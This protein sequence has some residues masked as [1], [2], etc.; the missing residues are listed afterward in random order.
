MKT[1]SSLLIALAIGAGSSWW[2]TSDRLHAK[3]GEQV[4]ALDKAVK[5][6]DASIE[7]L[8]GDVK[9]L[10]GTIADNNRR[11]LEGQK[12]YD[13]AVATAERDL[14]ALRKEYQARGKRIAELEKIKAPVVDVKSMS[15]EEIAVELGD[16][17]RAILINNSYEGGPFHY[18]F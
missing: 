15:T 1:I 14:A 16:C 4:A 10:R 5:D 2:F 12:A 7:N 9:T 13:E 17:R 3:Y 8:N 6:R 18:T 11:I